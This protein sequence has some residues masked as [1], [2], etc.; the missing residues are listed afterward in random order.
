MKSTV[1]FTFAASLIF[2]S[3][4][5]GYSFAE[6][7]RDLSSGKDFGHYIEAVPFVPQAEKDYCGPAALQTV[8][9][10]HGIEASQ[11]EIARAVFS[12]KAGGTANILLPAEARRRGL[13]AESASGSSADLFYIKEY[14]SEDLP[15]IVFVEMNYFFGSALHYF[16]LVGF[17]ETKKVLIAHGS[18]EPNL[19]LDEKKFLRRWEARGKWYMAAAPSDSPPAS[20]LIERGI[21]FENS[22]D[23]ASAKTSYA[24]A[25]ARA[26]TPFARAIA[27][28]N[29]GRVAIID[30]NASE[31]EAYLRSSKTSFDLFFKERP[32]AILSAEPKKAYADTLNALAWTLG[33]MQSKSSEA[34]ALI[35]EALKLFPKDPGFLD[36][37]SK[38]PHPPEN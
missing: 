6:V 34:D 22:G 37:Q 32:D 13:W 24:A 15:V 28:L 3:G 33:V 10:F 2:I 21:E 14:L 29:L 20:E 30:G 31:A 12:E 11:E 16:V 1:L 27:D 36:T 8:L 7:Y 19:V 4:C 26:R 25:S 17:D 35:K 18:A 38:I 5:A 9:K 23:F